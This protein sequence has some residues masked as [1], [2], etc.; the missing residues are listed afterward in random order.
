MPF[1]TVMTFYNVLTSME[2]L[3]RVKKTSRSN[4]S[5]Y[6]NNFVK[7][8]WSVTNFYF[9]LNAQNIFLKKYFAVRG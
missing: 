7:G 3:S 2:Q 8:K 9:I 4:V 1:I 5:P 6:L